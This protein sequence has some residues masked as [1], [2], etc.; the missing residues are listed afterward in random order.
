MRV[1]T[2]PAL[3][4][5]ALNAALEKWPEITAKQ[6]KAAIILQQ[7]LVLTPEETVRMLLAHPQILDYFSARLKPRH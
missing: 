3:L 5:A 1:A 4:D 6:R 2:K 7:R